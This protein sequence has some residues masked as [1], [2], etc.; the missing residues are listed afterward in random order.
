MGGHDDHDEQSFRVRARQPTRLDALVD[1]L[2]ALY[3][4]FVVGRAMVSSTF[5]LLDADAVGLSPMERLRACRSIARDDAFA[6]IALLS[7]VLA[8]LRPMDPA[9][10]LFYSMAGLACAL[11]CLGK[12]W[13]ARRERAPPAAYAPRHAA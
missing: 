3:A 10:S 11:L 12:A 5:A 9:T 13:L 8:L 7:L 6:A 4:T 1:R 2:R